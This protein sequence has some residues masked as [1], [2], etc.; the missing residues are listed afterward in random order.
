MNL[1][2]AFAKVER[3]LLVDADMRRPSIAR[4]L[5]LD[6][7]TPGLP[8]LLA[9]KANLNK[10]ISFHDDYNLEILKTGTI[11][12]DPLELLA[13]VRFSRIMK[14]L[15]TT[16]DRIII[17]CPP[18]LPVSDAAVL[19]TH[20]DSI[21]YVVKFDSTG[22]QQI[23]SG[24]QKLPRN[25]ASLAGIVLNQVDSRKAESYGDHGYSY[26]GYYEY[27]EADAKKERRTRHATAASL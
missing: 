18:L 7:S 20:A 16:Y 26:G 13:P 24:L 23:K 6:R 12:P 22:T 1:A 19:S 5:N 10:C 4:E 21:V 8:E 14:T 11:P 27:T 2:L 15:R 3:V 9:S 17:D 25:H